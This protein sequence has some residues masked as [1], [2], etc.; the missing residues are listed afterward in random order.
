MICVYFM[1]L[2]LWMQ[3]GICICIVHVNFAGLKITLDCY[4][5][6]EFRTALSG[7]DGAFLIN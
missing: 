2:P 4:E 3:F 1:L 5:P 6:M 7:V